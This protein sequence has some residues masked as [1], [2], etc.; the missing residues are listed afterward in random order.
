MVALGAWLLWQ[1]L[2]GRRISPSMPVLWQLVAVGLL[3]QVVGNLGSQWS[4]GIVGLAVTIPAIFGLMLTSAAVLGWLMLGERVSRRSAAAISLLLVS[5]VLLGIG[6]EA[7][8][9]SI[10]ARDEVAY[11][12][13][14]V[15]LAIGAACMAGAVYSLLSIATRHAVTSPLKKGTG[16]ETT[17]ENPAKDT[18]REVPVPFLQRAAGQA[19]P[20]ATVAFLITLMGVVSLGPLSLA[21]V[22][23]GQMLATPPEQAAMM[24]LAGFFNLVGFFALI[25]AL[26]RTTVVHA[27]VLNASQVALAGLGG[28][29]LFSEPPNGWLLLGIGLTIVGIISIDRPAGGEQPLD[30]HI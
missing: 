25:L 18:A 11:D 26:Q 7:A 27:N 16:S 14:L 15:A 8:G 13:L 9:R 3:I 24:V 28:M 1:A 4:L 22:G 30:Q 23:P 29:L 17:C 19:T 10:S 2:R 5:L 12:P 21:T 6:A 20:P